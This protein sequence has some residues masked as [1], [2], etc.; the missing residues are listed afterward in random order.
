MPNINMSV[1]LREKSGH[2]CCCVAEGKYET[3]SHE[4]AEE[5]SWLSFPLG[6]LAAILLN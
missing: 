6:G 5:W 3:S 4:D 1:L 2:S